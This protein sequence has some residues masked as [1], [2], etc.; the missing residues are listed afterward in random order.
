MV[1]YFASDII[2]RATQLADIENSDFVSYSEKIALLNEAYQSLYQKGI[3]KD[4]NAF[5]RHINTTST[6]IHLPP[7][8]YQLKAVTIGNGVYMQQVLRRPANQ[9]TT[10]LSYDII[11]NTLK[12]NGHVT[13][14]TITV[15]YYPTPASLSFPSEDKELP[16]SNILDM[17]GHLYVAFDNVNTVYVGDITTNDTVEINEENNTLH[18]YK[19]HMNDDYVIF[20]GQTD[21]KLYNIAQD[22]L[23]TATKQIVEY[24]GQTF[25]YEDG[26]LLFPDSGT[27]AYEIDIELPIADYIVLNNRQTKYLAWNKDG[28]ISNGEAIDVKKAITKLYA[29]DD[30]VCLATGT[31]YYALY[32]FEKQAIVKETINRLPVIS[33]IGTNYDTGYGLL[34]K[35]TLGNTKVL[36]SFQE[37]TELNFPNNTYFVFLSYL[38]AL[39]FKTKQGSD[40]S[41][42]VGLV[43]LAESTFYDSLQRDDWNSTRITNAY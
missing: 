22:E 41:Q 1:K 19:T 2:K 39:S 12:I 36:S 3:N 25:Y 23:T 32:S 27:V 11:N 42:L 28:S 21:T 9:S 10:N 7:D 30:I 8:F 5:V 16:Y 35:K 40:T 37:D 18:Q 24:K 14:G 38:L 13:G 26:N 34:C 15:E 6:V 4:I 17:R 31:T 33:R 43:D 29:Y 20:F